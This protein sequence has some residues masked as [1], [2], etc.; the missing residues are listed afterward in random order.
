[1]RS[2]VGFYVEVLDLKLINQYDTVAFFE[3]GLVI[4]DADT[5]FEYIS[6]GEVSNIESNLVLYFIVSDIEAM[7]QML[8][9][10]QC[11]LIHGIQTQSWGEK[12]IRLYDP[13]G[14]VVEL[15]DGQ[16]IKPDSE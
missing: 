1:M 4:H 15:G 5:Y 6:K 7:Y 9:E 10:K 3:N 11:V 13:V 16:H 14:N 12:C 8:K 2:L